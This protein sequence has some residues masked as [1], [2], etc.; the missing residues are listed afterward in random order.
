MNIAFIGDMEQQILTVSMLN[1]SSLGENDTHKQK[2]IIY[3]KWLCMKQLTIFYQDSMK[4]KRNHLFTE[5][6]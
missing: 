6:L 3:Q 2:T 4:N 5:N 1:S